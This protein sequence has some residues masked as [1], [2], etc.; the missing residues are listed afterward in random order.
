MALARS[1]TPHKMRQTR[2]LYLAHAEL[3]G[4]KNIGVKNQLNLRELQAPHYFYIQIRTKQTF[5]NAPA[6]VGTLARLKLVLCSLNKRQA[7]G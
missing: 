2:Y 5:C 3:A 6:D 7:P 1:D 4:W